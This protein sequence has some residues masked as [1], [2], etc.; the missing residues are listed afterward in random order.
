MWMVWVNID[1]NLYF[2]FSLFFYVFFWCSKLFCFFFCI[3]LLIVEKKLFF[4]LLSLL[5]FNKFLL[6]AS[7]QW[8]GCK[9]SITGWDELCFNLDQ[10]LVKLCDQNILDQQ[11]TLES[12][13]ISW[14]MASHY[15]TDPLAR[16]QQNPEARCH[17]LFWSQISGS[18]LQ[19]GAN[20]D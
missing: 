14:L 18:R 6:V 7:A 12:S 11:T 13:I 2:F 1:I 5:I 20:F 19:L 8:T 3:F 9:C 10:Q 16:L 15:L 17:A 4:F